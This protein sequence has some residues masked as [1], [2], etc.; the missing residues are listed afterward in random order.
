[1]ANKEELAKKAY[2]LAYDYDLKFGCCPQCVL[3]AVKETIGYVTDDI[4]KASHTLSGGCGLL[5]YGTCGALSGG[6]LALGAKYGRD[7]E[8]FGKG[9]F[10]K[11]FMV[12]KQL[13]EKVEE[14]FKGTT[15]DDIQNVCHGK[16]YNMW[17]A[18]EIKDLKNEKFVKY[19]ADMT[20][21]IAQ[22]C[23]EMMI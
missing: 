22:W 5:G 15:C 16:T 17:D 18:N 20:G 19:C 14:E 9:K 21:K 11:S 13:M 23:V 4:I 6:L 2:D 8:G 3:L 10:M 1:M 7:V 12:A